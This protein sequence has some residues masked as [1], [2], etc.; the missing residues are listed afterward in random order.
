MATALELNL[1]TSP[2]GQPSQSPYQQPSYPPP[3]PPL[4]GG[5]PPGAEKK[6]TAATLAILLGGF[7]A[8]KF[9]LGYQQEGI[10]MLSG[11]I[12]G[13]ILAV[14]VGILTCG[15]GFVL[16]LIPV[17]ISVIGLVEGVMYLSKSDDEFVATYIQG[18]RPWF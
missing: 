6:V 10:M 17:A 3:V 14:I 13:F 2:Y 9:V 11:T 1:L 7:G 8:H 16:L 18:R 4:P 12:G 5:P 15:I